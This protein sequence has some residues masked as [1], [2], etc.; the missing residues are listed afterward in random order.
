M[1]EHKARQVAFFILFLVGLTCPQ[2]ALAQ[3]R[4][5]LLKAGFIEKFTHFV[6]WPERSL[7]SDSIFRIAVIGRHQF[8]T[9]LNDIFKQVRVK[10]KPVRISYISSIEEIG[11]SSILIITPSVGS[12]LEEMLRS[13]H[14][15]NIL[16]IS[17]T[18]GFGKRG[19]MIN[20]FLKDQFI[21]YEINQKTLNLSGLKMSS[22]LLNSAETILK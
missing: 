21:R 4:E 1:K 8:G 19:V 2:L 16:T 7:N 13:I 22:L 6:E 15:K 10:N 9:A 5:Y 18:K 12:K 17:E 11:N 3:S 14:G 20:M